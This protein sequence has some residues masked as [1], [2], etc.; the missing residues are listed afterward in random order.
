MSVKGSIAAQAIAPLPFT[1]NH[2]HS[3]YESQIAKFAKI[4]DEVDS[5]E[6]K[7][8]IY[9]TNK[10][11]SGEKVS[12][13]SQGGI[14]STTFFALMFLFAGCALGSCFYKR[15]LAPDHVL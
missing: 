13:A 4:Q 7:V 11:A 12:E 8:S 10:K 14:C 9:L 1:V 6:Q 5:A 2:I 15:D 3:F